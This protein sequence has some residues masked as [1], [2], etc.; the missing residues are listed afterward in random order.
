MPKTK[1]IVYEAFKCDWDWTWDSGASQAALVVKNAPANVG[2]GRDSG[3][4][5]G[6]GRSPG[7]GND[8]PPVFLPGES[9]GQS[10]WWTTVHGVT[11][12]VGHD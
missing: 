2:D 10:S 11:K 12:R 7:E 6:L 1:I 9:H 4:I 8:N 5:P 3:L